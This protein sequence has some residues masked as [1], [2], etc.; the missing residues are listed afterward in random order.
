[1][2]VK[3]PLAYQREID[4][5][6]GL[7]VLGVVL[8][9]AFPSRMRGGFVGVDIFF[10]ISGYLITRIICNELE[11]ERFSFTAFYGRRI[12]RLFPALVL[13]IGMCLLAGVLVM[14]PE[15]LRRLGR[16]AVAGT[17]F[18]PNIAAYR[19]AGSYFAGAA[20]QK[21]LLHLWS[22]GIEEQF[23]LLW[24]MV[25]VLLARIRWRLSLAVA[26]LFVLTFLANL[27]LSYRFPRAAFFLPIGRLHELLLGALV[28]FVP[29]PPSQRLRSY[30]ATL[31]SLMLM[32]GFAVITPARVFPGVWV[33][34]PVGGTALLL[35][36]NDGATRIA[37]ALASSPLV[38]VGHISYPLYLWHW[39]LLS[40]ATVIE[41]GTPGRMIR[42]LCVCTAFLLAWIS[43][44][45]LE[46]PV[47][48]ASSHRRN[49]WVQIL[50]SLMVVVGIS[51]FL[52][53]NSGGFPSRFAQLPQ[54]AQTSMAD[55]P[56]VPVGRCWGAPA[57][58]SCSKVDSD[59]E[60]ILVL[61]DS[62]AKPVA[63]GLISEL[64]QRDVRISVA[65][66][67]VGEGG[68]VPFF[69]VESYD[70]YGASRGCQ[71]DLDR[72]LKW[73]LYD[74]SVRTVLLVGRWASRVGNATGFGRSEDFGAVSRGRYR[75]SI[76]RGDRG[77]NDQAF[78]S[79]LTE[80]VYTLQQAGRRVVF[81]HQVPEFGFYPPYCGRRPVLIA[82]ARDSLRGQ[83]CSIEKKAVEKRQA[84]Y[85][86]LLHQIL[87]AFPS[88]LTVDPLEVLCS[89]P[90]CSMR[91]SN[92][93][94]LYRDDDHVNADG[95]LLVGRLVLDS[96]YHA[97][98]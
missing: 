28:V 18:V 86:K 48:L 14:L 81:L 5:L 46:R 15:E 6:R 8:F 33:L 7:A 47:R 38:F 92:G 97:G 79:G 49:F 27:V 2:V 80:T 63:L 53:F 52:M 95:G 74:K 11:E 25:L 23:Y 83:G 64:A 77:G 67:S 82:R 26:G 54:R 45:F 57:S 85:R 44:R 35:L 42:V 43:Y 89:G 12:R 19:E 76:D 30:L 58:L 94:L 29:R 68:C 40:F 16:H 62:H 72:I 84:P 60:K 22:L 88:V 70:A 39:P 9:H 71:P 3:S 69:H 10:P 75:Y 59:A 66:R 4:G 51:G 17:L 24:P 87:S 37:R 91:Y 61:G 90:T 93:T 98:H 50:A 32:V 78:T 13:V 31:G 20:D 55:A 56:A 34:L 96:L 1:M 73:A 65:F 21:P 36:V 41:G